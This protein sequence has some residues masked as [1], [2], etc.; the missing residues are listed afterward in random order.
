MSSESGFRLTFCN[1]GVVALARK[2]VTLWKKPEISSQYRKWL[3]WGMSGVAKKAEKAEK[4]EDG[5]SA[6]D[7]V[8]P[9]KEEY[10]FPVDGKLVDL[11]SEDHF[12]GAVQEVVYL[13]EPVILTSLR[14]HCC[15]RN[16]KSGNR[17]PGIGP[18][19]SSFSQWYESEQAES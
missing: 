10:T 8:R 5:C 2:P 7:Y 11:E 13:F 4:S 19:T 9:P 17:S 6:Q 12:L 1:R 15:T 3:F 18:K 16:L 14:L